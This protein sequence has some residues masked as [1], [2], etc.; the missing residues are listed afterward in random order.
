M[1]RCS[2]CGFIAARVYVTREY[3]EVDDRKRESGEVGSE[4]GP[5]EPVPVC[6]VSSF[7]I[8]EEVEVL[9]KAACDEP[10][11]NSIGEWISPHWANHVKQVLNTDRECESFTKW[12][13]GCTPKEHREMMD[14][15]RMQKWQMER[16]EADKKWRTEQEEKYSKAEWKRYIFLAIMTIVSVIVGVILGHLI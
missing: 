7:N 2:E 12:Q 16:E 15:E 11:Q 8:K 5:L 10:T 9:R 13:Q 6:F 1:A 3:L 4:R 14:R